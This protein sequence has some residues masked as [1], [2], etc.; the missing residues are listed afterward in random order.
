MDDYALALDH[1]AQSLTKEY[2][3]ATRISGYKRNIVLKGIEAGEKRMD[4][5]LSDANSNILSNT[6]VENMVNV[7]KPAVIKNK[8]PFERNP[9]RDAA[10]GELINFNSNGGKLA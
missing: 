2:L 10:N 6:R 5:I 9:K 1:H 3:E 4:T 7:R 8:A